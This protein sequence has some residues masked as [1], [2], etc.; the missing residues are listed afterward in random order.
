MA[1]AV[2]KI[3]CELDDQWKIKIYLGA[4]KDKFGK[5][6]KSRI[7]TRKTMESRINIGNLVA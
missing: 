1:P 5:T 7:D 4:F 6:M 2:K 3:M